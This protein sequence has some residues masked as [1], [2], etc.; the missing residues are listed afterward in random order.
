MAA[1]PYLVPMQAG[2]P[3]SIIIVS[4]VAY[5]LAQKSAGAGNPW[6]MLAIAYGAAFIISLTLA[7]ATSGAAPPRARTSGLLLGLA[8]L[9][10][11]TG[12]FFL[13]RSGWSL[14]TAQV[15]SSTTVAAILAVI[16]VL[17]FGEALTFYRVT[18]IILAA[19][20]ATLIARGAA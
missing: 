9:G 6:P 16:G 10:I 2:I 3:I 15:L 19:A 17:V 7:L 11:E 13:Y 4:G 5:H 20:G 8:A 18:G 12:F 1:A 14:A